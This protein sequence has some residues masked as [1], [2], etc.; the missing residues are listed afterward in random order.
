M[1]LEQFA[2]FAKISFP[3][4]LIILDITCLATAKIIPREVTNISLSTKI[5]LLEI[6]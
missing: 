1:Q 2:N 6:Y 5:N 3:F 4:S